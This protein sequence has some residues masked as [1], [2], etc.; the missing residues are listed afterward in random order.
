MN[1]KHIEALL[2]TLLCIVFIALCILMAT[3]AAAYEG[4]RVTTRR[5]DA[6]HEG[7]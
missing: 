4:D 6:L 2:I 7:R 3:P 5:Q 1:H